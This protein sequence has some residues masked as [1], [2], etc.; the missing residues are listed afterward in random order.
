MDLQDA[1]EAGEKRGDVQR[2]EATS[3]VLVTIEGG[4]GRL[5]LVDLLLGYGPYA[6]GRIYT[7]HE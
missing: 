2:G 1:R 7:H 4:G 6:H 5:H 3:G